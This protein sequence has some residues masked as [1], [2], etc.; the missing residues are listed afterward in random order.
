[1]APAAAW[2]RITGSDREARERYE[3]DSRGH[4]CREVGRIMMAT[5]FRTAALAICL[6]LSSIAALGD[7]DPGRAA[8]SSA[9]LRPAVVD[10]AIIE[11][12]SSGVWGFIVNVPQVEEGSATVTAPCPL[13]TT[14]EYGW[15]MGQQGL[16]PNLNG[17][18]VN[19][20]FEWNIGGAPGIQCGV[21]TQA[22]LDQVGQGAPHG[23][24]IEAIVLSSSRTFNDVLALAEGAAIIGAGGPEIGGEIGGACYSGDLAICIAM[25]HR[26]GLV[27]NTVLA[28]PATD[29]TQARAVSLLSSM[30][31]TMLAGLAEHG[32]GSAPAGPTTIATATTAAPPTTAAVAVSP[33]TQSP[34]AAPAPPPAPLV[35]RLPPVPGYAYQPWSDARIDEF[36]AGPFTPDELDAYVAEFAGIDVAR[37]GQVI[38]WIELHLLHSEFLNVPNLD[39]VVLDTLSGYPYSPGP[40][41][42]ERLSLV[43]RRSW[44][45]AFPVSRRGRGTRAGSCSTSSPMESIPAQPASSSSLSRPRNT[46]RPNRRQPQP[47]PVDRE[48]AAEFAGE[49]ADARLEAGVVAPGKAGDSSPPVKPES[50]PVKP[51]S[52]PVKPESSPVKRIITTREARVITTDEARVITTREAESPPSEKPESPPVKPESPPSEKPSYTTRETGVIT[53]RETGVDA[54]REAGVA[55]ATEV[56]GPEVGSKAGI[57]SELGCLGTLGWRARVPLLAAKAVRDRSTERCRGRW[58]VSFSELGLGA[59]MPGSMS[60]AISRLHPAACSR[61]FGCCPPASRRPRPRRPSKA[62]LPAPASRRPSRRLCRLSYRSGDSGR[63]LLTT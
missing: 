42:V 36:L 58:A 49:L 44:F 26:S 37:D 35:D 57:D 27:L 48:E 56:I 61:R 15:F 4:V 13:M 24:I 45:D 32:I 54:T 53:T 51:E 46:A 6:P 5:S 19:V 10:E 55:G 34:I 43:V 22:H 47:R 20:F 2:P 30:I 60:R 8:D 29:V 9:T 63:S 3:V 31:E 39:Q 23:A 38:G 21:D 33:T 11:R 62:F 40:S 18:A 17:W 16:S 41:T 50:S 28:G 52:S 25:W 59:S 12:A 7:A 1:M 14:D